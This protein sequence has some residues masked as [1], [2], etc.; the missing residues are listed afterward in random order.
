MH[1]R[2]TTLFVRSRRRSLTNAEHHLVARRVAGAELDG[3]PVP[4]VEPVLDEAG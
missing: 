4:L 1:T 2:S 3:A